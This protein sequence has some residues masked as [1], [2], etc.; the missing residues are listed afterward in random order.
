MH[1][2]TYDG[3]NWKDWSPTVE[4]RSQG[5]CTG[6]AVVRKMPDGTYLPTIALSPI[7]EGGTTIVLVD[8]EL[9]NANGSSAAGNG[10]TLLVNTEHGTG[11]WYE[12]DAPVHTLQEPAAPQDGFCPN[13][14]S[15]LLPSAEGKSLLELAT[16]FVGRRN[17][18]S[19][20]GV[21]RR[22]GAEL[23]YPDGG[24]R[25]LQAR[26]SGERPL[27]RRDERLARRG[28]TDPGVVV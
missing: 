18:D 27:P 13:Y 3:V 17:E 1:A 10:A 12:V 15:A 21:Q 7:P 9:H 28:G 22:R 11:V 8:Q 14:S 19:A 4:A 5:D 23:P 24:E 20:V 2:R 25:V 6:M 26:V 16:N